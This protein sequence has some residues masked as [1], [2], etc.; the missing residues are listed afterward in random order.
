MS[1]TTSSI[2]SPTPS[3]AVTLSDLERSGPH[4]VI[5]CGHIA[6]HVLTRAQVLFKLGEG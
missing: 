3:V 6:A 1:A 2:A 4:T 5:H